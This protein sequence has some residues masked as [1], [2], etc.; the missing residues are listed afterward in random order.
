MH[1]CYDM[2]R[3]EMLLEITRLEA[4]VH[5]LHGYEKDY[6]KCTKKCSKVEKQLH[7][8]NVAISKILSEI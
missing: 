2:T 6:K 5:R 3:Q 7:T 4:G 1:R 8:L